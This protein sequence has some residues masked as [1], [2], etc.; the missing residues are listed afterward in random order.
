M[1]AKFGSG[2]LQCAINPLSLGTNTPSLADLRLP[3]ERNEKM[4]RNAWK[5]DGYRESRRIGFAILDAENRLQTLWLRGYRP[6]LMALLPGSACH[7]LT[8]TGST[9]FSRH[10]YHL[11]SGLELCSS[12]AG[13]ATIP[14]TESRY[15][16]ELVTL[17]ELS[18]VF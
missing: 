9:W 3:R 13:A 16:R 6:P 12:A 18:P 14:S 2:I 17:S 15:N 11:T 5:A 10:F 1:I 7:P 4:R 8:L